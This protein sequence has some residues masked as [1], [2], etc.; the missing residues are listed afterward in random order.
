VLPTLSCSQLANT[1]S[2]LALTYQAANL[3]CEAGAGLSSSQQLAGGTGTAA[4]DPQAIVEFYT[5]SFPDQSFLLTFRETVGQYLA[6][7]P[8]SFTAAAAVDAEAA[9]CQQGDAACSACNPAHLA[10]IL[11][12]IAS[13][14]I[15]VVQ[16][17]PIGE[18]LSP[19]LFSS[20]IYNWQQWHLRMLSSD[21]TL[22][23]FLY[24]LATNWQQ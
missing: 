4:A 5:E 21:V 7:H 17:L 1:V 9:D 23:F 6:Q 12:A 20:T 11:A 24:S 19:F 8:A 3:S 16:P 18:D 22:Y 10:K 15:M 2:S 13:L 14:P